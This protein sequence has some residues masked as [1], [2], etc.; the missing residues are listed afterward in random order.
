M[1]VF[2]SLRTVPLG[3]GG[4]IQG[5]AHTKPTAHHSILECHQIPNRY[6]HAASRQDAPLKGRP[7]SIAIVPGVSW[8]FSPLL[9]AGSSPYHCPP[10]FELCGYPARLRFEV[11]AIFSSEPVR[12]GLRFT[13]F[14][15]FSN[16]DKKLFAR[17][18]QVGPGLRVGSILAASGPL[19]S[20]GAHQD[21]APPR[22]RGGEKRGKGRGGGGEEVGDGAG[23]HDEGVTATD[24][25]F[26][27]TRPLLPTHMH[28]G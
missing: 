7:S 2:S 20:S 8:A 21:Q 24:L 17:P 19:L 25:F 23:I 9:R 15:S 16:L 4:R 1:W 5:R 6:D 27:A 11:I 13:C 18:S 12:D 14:L 22:N 28:A 3:N 10:P 26:P